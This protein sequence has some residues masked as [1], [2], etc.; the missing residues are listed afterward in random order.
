M[1]RI[2]L[3]F[4]LFLILVDCNAQEINFMND[5]LIGYIQKGMSN[6]K[7][8]G[9][10][11]LVIKE[12]NVIV[13]KGFGF[14]N[15]EQKL[16]FD[17]ETAFFIASNTKLFTGTML[18]NL[19]V[20]GKLDLND[21]VKKYLPNYGLYNK[22][23]TE[24]VTLTDLL[25]HRIGTD[26]FQGDFT[27]WNSTLS[28]N[29]VISKMRYM[30]PEHIFRQ[31][32]GYCNSCY[33]TA[34]EIASHIVGTKW[35]KYI[36]DSIFKPL[37]MNNT[38][39]INNNAIKRF[40]KIATPYTLN[41]QGE[42]VVLP[43]DQW[44]NLGPAAAI[45]SNLN[46]MEKWLRFQL[47]SGKVNGNPIIP[48]EAIA[49]TRKARI[50]FSSTWN[51]SLNSHFDAYGLGLFMTDYNGHQVFYHTGGA[52][53]MVSSVCFVPEKN[54]GMVIFA[55][56]DQQGF[57][58][59][60][61]YQILDYYLGNK[62]KNRSMIDLPYFLKDLDDEKMRVKNL[63][64]RIQ[65]PKFKNSLKEYEGRYFNQ[66]YGNSYV[67]Q[68]QDHLEIS[69]Q[70]H[71]ALKGYLEQMDQGEWFLYFNNVGYGIFSTSFKTKNNK[72]YSFTIKVKDFIEYGSYVFTKV[73]KL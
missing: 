13:K 49:E 71:P 33:M 28:R 57:F 2:L 62:Y 3:F 40:S 20:Q 54:L 46:D 22:L 53:G 9:L 48:W 25:A 23:N 12:G 45:V 41:D 56:N 36:S 27:Y 38:S 15:V 10:G 4:V 43:Y 1:K 6:W 66:Q 5:S 34:G 31:D 11:L 24:T 68:I 65:N 51:K 69:F 42:L 59:S 64:S 52:S 29:D 67:K 50:I 55:N 32:F 30:R 37:E 7:L 61:R 16:P 21:K 70:H 73:M 60:L 72:P 19:S 58:E 63:R 44:D 18:S 35:E 26:D 47:D 39:S 14:R 17:E 8:P